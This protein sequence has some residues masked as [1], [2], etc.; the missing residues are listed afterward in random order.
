MEANY[1]KAGASGSF[2]AGV[3]G[4]KLVT[5]IAGLLAGGA[6]VVKGGAVLTEKVVAKVA[7]KAESAA[8][9]ADK[10]AATAESVSSGKLSGPTENWKNYT[11]AETVAQTS[12][13]GRLVNADKAVID[14]NKVTSYALNSEHPV[15]GNKAKVFE[16]ALGYNQSN[17]ADLIAKVQ[18]G[19][20]SNPVKMGSSDKFGQRMTI[21]MPITGPNGKTAIVRT[22][23][24]Y[25]VGSTTP[26]MTTIYVNK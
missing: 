10:M 23:W 7:G 24:I 3:E 18:E 9:N 8:V 20:K 5:D 22:G 15:G 1:Q 6:G 11:Y 13:T 19:V 16:S 14:P 4:G 2:N 12:A 17:A 25:D 26:R 21:D